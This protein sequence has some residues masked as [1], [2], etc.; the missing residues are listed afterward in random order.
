MSCA[1]EVEWHKTVCEGREYVEDDEL[2]G[3]P[4]T[5]GTGENE[6]VQKI[7]QIISIKMMAEKVSINKETVRQILHENLTKI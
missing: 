1:H 3:R 6:N 2:C 5:S 4:C 7:K